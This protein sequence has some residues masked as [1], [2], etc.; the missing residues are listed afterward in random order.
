MSGTG[1]INGNAASGSGIVNL[2]TNDASNKITGTLYVNPASATLTKASSNVVNVIPNAGLSFNNVIPLIV[3]APTIAHKVT[4]VTFPWSP[5]T[6]A[7]SQD[8]DYDS[9]TATA[10]MTVDATQHDIFIHTKTLTLDGSG[11]IVIN[12]THKVYLFIDN[13]IVYSSWAAI[14]DG[15]TKDQLYIIIKSGSMVLTRN[16]PITANLYIK[17]GNFGIT[18]GTTINGSVIASGASF[19]TS[20]GGITINGDLYVPNAD[21]TMQSGAIINGAV[22]VKSLTV[23]GGCSI[24]YADNG[25]VIPSIILPP[26]PPMP[27]PTS[28]P[29]PTETTVESNKAMVILDGGVK[30]VALYLSKVDRIAFAGDYAYIKT[31]MSTSKDISNVNLTFTLGAGG[32]GFNCFELIPNT[33]SFAVPAAIG[34]S[35]TFAPTAVPT[36]T[37]AP[38]GTLTAGPISGGD[39]LAGTTKTHILKTKIRKDLGLLTSYPS[40]LLNNSIDMTYDVIDNGK[41]ATVTVRINNPL[42]AITRSGLRFN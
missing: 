26:P 34:G 13:P 35:N 15:G 23:T 7:I 31:E 28:T 40:L 16:S 1:V 4:S 32:N 29:P 27:T 20:S 6:P 33:S 14:N 12:G 9:I 38:D 36:C 41:T 37:V 39:M 24:N 42:T 11:G 25:V 2:T 22:T 21:V 5:I 19:A 17:N 30:L 18:A 8:T 3:D 10:A